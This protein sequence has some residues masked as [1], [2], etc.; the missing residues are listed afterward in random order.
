MTYLKMCNCQ[1]N[2]GKLAR[3]A[4]LASNTTKIYCN[5][6]VIMSFFYIIHSIIIK[7]WAYTH[8]FRYGVDLVAHRS[9]KEISQGFPQ[10]G[11]VAPQLKNTPTPH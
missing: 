5:R 11:D 7:N 1:T 9:G 4:S 10:W 6:L 3:K 8:N 2:V